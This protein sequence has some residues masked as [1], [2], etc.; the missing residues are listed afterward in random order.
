MPTTSTTPRHRSS[1]K[2]LPAAL[3]ALAGIGRA[4]SLAATE[5]NPLPPVSG[6]RAPATLSAR[7]IVRYK[8]GAALLRTHAAQAGSRAV[9]H[10]A[11]ALAARHGVTLHDGRLLTER[12]QL[13]RGEGLS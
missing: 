12:M 7:V 5:H 4:A 3:L 11:Q 8:A 10:Y 13:V 1:L 6:A 2:H 9:P